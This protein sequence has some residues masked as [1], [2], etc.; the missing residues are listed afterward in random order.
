MTVAPTHYSPA[1]DNFPLS[2]IV[3]TQILK[4]IWQQSWS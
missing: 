2:L 4:M 3:F 1:G